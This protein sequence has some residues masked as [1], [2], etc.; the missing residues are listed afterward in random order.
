MARKTET[1]NKSK[2]PTKTTPKSNPKPKTTA[3]TKKK[4]V[5]LKV[6]TDYLG[7]V[8]EVD[9]FT[10]LIARV[11]QQI[12]KLRKTLPFDALAFTGTSGSAVAYPISA[13]LKI[14]LI[15]VRKTEDNNHYFQAIEGCVGAKRYLI[16]DD[17]IES[18]ETVRRIIRTIRED[19]CMGEQAEA[20]GVFLYDPTDRRK[21]IDD[22]PIITNR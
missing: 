13:Q 18:G 14:P 10:K 7:S 19:A 12:E 20:V 3:K 22:L 1:K 6:R 4:S 2:A 15:C 21:Q 5:K 11:S 8:Y 17:F 9:R 16:I